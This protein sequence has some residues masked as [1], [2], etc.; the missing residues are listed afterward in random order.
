MNFVQVNVPSN[1]ATKNLKVTR[2]ENG[3]RKLQISS[4]FLP[5][6]GFEKGKKVIEKSLGKGKG[7]SIILANE[8]DASI[9]KTKRVYGRTYKRRSNNPFE[10]LTETSNQT[11]INES[12]PHE[13]DSVNVVFKFGILVIK[14]IINKASERIKKIIDSKTPFSVFAACTSGVDAHIT[15]NAG[16]QIDS[17]LEY[18]PHEKRDKNRDLSETGVMAA[19][20]NC[21][22]ANVFNEDI[23]K[24]NTSQLAQHTQNLQSS[25]LTISL[26][27]DDF[28]NAKSKK[29]KE[30]SFIE[31]SST[32]DMAYNGLKLIEALEFPMILME[33]VPNFAKS[34]IG[35]MWDLQLRRMGYTTYSSILDARD[36]GGY[37]SRS[38]YFHFATSLPVS[39]RFP[40]TMPLNTEKLWDKFIAPRI[41]DFRDVSH[42][43][44]IKEAITSGR[45]RT[46][47]GNCTYSGSPMKSQSRQAKD[48]LY[49]RENEGD[50][51]LFPD[52][53]L[54]KDLMTIPESYTLNSVNGEQATEIIGQSLDGSLYRYIIEN[55]KA[56]INLFLKK[57][58]SINA[59]S[60]SLLSY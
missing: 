2:Y 55:I 30:Q 28:S 24:V 40:E 49:I 42:T 52:E 34:D 1:L 8:E 57:V 21:K 56:H 45:L 3:K 18:R 23:Y 51:F 15:Q 26:Q 7:Y 5:L 10:T 29:L 12:I 20:E 50:P 19:I 27:C 4:N 48:S 44:T 11:L 31:G 33:N 37:T 9:A 32:L 41:N 25:L 60:P 47:D 59:N 16:F 17:V 53:Q 13:C 14:P 46:L 54:L 22:V 6:F 36:F 39:F 58:N 35:Q 38:R 43:K